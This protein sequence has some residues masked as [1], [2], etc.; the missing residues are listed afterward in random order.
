MNDDEDAVDALLRSVTD[1]DVPPD[2]ERRLSQREEAFR[3]R[4]YARRA[5]AWTRWSGFLRPRRL[6]WVAGTVLAGTVL[7]V[8][9]LSVLRSPGARLY[10]AAIEALKTV[11]T[12]HMTGWRTSLERYSRSAADE[13][14]PVEDRYLWEV[15]E[16]VTEDGRPRQYE[17]RGPIVEWDDGERRYEHNEHFDRL[18]IQESHVGDLAE[19]LQ[20]ARGSLDGLRSKGARITD[21][22]ERRI[23][24]RL[25]Q[26][27][28]AE[29]ASHWRR[30]WWLDKETDLPI[31]LTG[32][33]WE[34]DQWVLPW[35]LTVAYNDRVPE[36]IASYVPPEGVATE[37]HMSV[38]P[39][40]ETW[41]LHLRRLA[42]RYRNVPLPEKMELVPRESDERFGAL[43]RG[44]MP[45][46]EGYRVTPL[47]GTLG[48][49]LRGN[50][51]HPIGSLRVPEDAQR[52]TLNHDLVHKD[53][54][55]LREQ[56]QFVL[57]L[58]GLELV[59]VTEERTVWVAHY[60]GRALK[61]WREVEAPVPNPRHRPLRPGMA[62][63]FGMT[64][65]RKL[66]DAVAWAQDYG[67]TARGIIIVDETGLPTEAEDRESIAVASEG[68]H[69]GWP[70]EESREIAKRW[71]AKEFGVTFA[72]ETRP[73]TVYVVREKASP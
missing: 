53:G 30:E 1:V 6:A 21:L 23:A 27:V 36:A 71:F 39:R 62:S 16:W 38:D 37:Y 13:S 19:A 73:M 7:L 63:T 66:F 33:Q 22:G 46:I 24:D 18:W 65:L 2:V 47:Q 29:L 42:A 43:S 34:N 26:G 49:Y 35:E 55:T 4:M 56:Q 10:A 11:R 28:R 15:W 58:M 48:D 20:N 25:A 72:E 70:Y 44:R 45:G 59:E 51:L 32:C 60:D 52:K 41:R 68:P 54:V 69:W 64:T 9:A 8:A 3:Q 40:F 14:I 5:S 50:R 31:E 61:P 12:V 57:N 67:L 17:R